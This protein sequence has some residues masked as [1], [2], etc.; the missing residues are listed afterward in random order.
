[1][2][3]TP[4]AFLETAL[5]QREDRIPE[6]IDCSSLQSTSRQVVEESQRPLD[7]LFTRRLDYSPTGRP[8]P[9]S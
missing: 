8:P 9:E 6:I 3:S 7:D 2:E 4:S 1:L 5:P